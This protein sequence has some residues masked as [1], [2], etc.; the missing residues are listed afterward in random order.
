M[1]EVDGLP[2]G[3]SGFSTTRTGGVSVGPWSSFN[4]GAACGDDPDAVAENRR[5]LR[6]Q[7]PGDPRWLKQVH[8]TRVV[9]LDDWLPGIEAD[10][11]WTDRSGD[12][13][14]VQTADCL[15][16]LLADQDAQLVAAAHAGWRGLAA[17]VL[18][19]LVHALPLSAER[20]VAWIGPA[21][22]AGQYQV[23]EPVREAFVA[24]DRRFEQAFVTT[25]PGQFMA[26]LKWIARAQ[27]EQAGL[28]AI[29]NCG[30]CTAS[31]AELFFSYRRDG[32]CGRM[33][34]LIW[35]E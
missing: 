31:D 3:V 25:A 9:H 1:I 18:P 28:T 22:G 11:A 6:Q 13:I 14:A 5:R 16:V 21:I 19:A 7:L 20:L 24:L 10:A 12:V 2:S 35:K 23:D 32:T 30:L 8:G 27:L 33:A 34:S 26:D 15:P 4:L 29:H 17:G